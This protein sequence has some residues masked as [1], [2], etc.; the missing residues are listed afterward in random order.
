M[1]YR[2][3]CPMPSLPSEGSTG[4]HSQ[5]PGALETAMESKTSM[6]VVREHLL[7]RVCGCG[8]GKEGR[9]CREEQEAGGEAGQ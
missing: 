5:H 6:G 9:D 7:P 4:K 1:G 8:V 2:V 3:V